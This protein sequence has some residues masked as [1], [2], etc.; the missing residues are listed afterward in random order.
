MNAGLAI[1]AITDAVD[2]DGAKDCLQGSPL[3]TAVCVQRAGRCL[4]HVHSRTDVAGTALLN[5]SLQEQPLQ[6]AAAEFLLM[7]DPVEWECKS[8]SRG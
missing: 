7:F 6:L 5:M 4:D 3:E 8:R 1:V 2:I